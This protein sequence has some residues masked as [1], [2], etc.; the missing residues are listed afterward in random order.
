MNSKTL[1][2]TIALTLALGT[3][4]LPGTAAARDYDRGGDRQEHRDNRDH[5]RG[6]SRRHDNDRYRRHERARYEH[7]R[8]KRHTHWFR[9]P[10]VRYG[11]YDFGHHRDGNYDPNRIIR[12]EP[13]W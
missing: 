13:R 10:N 12:I 2:S 8:Y 4:A 3:L 1:I 9:F 6:D 5:D 11:Y 7:R